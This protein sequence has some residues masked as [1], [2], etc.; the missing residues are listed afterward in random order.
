[1][2]GR[3]IHEI[4]HKSVRSIVFQTLKGMKH[5]KEF[6]PL[7]KLKVWQLAMDFSVDYYN[8]IV[9][10]SD[11][12]LRNQMRRSSLSVSSNIAEGF[13]RKYDKEFVRFLKIAIGSLYEIQSQ[14]TFANRIGVIDVDMDE[15][16]FRISEIRRRIS[17]FI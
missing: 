4:N 16:N 17:L 15:V 11:F 12:G 3:F 6:N 14:F 7:E 9:S 10:I 5:K 2:S 8:V 1:M 13:G